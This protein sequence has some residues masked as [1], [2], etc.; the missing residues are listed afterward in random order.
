MVMSKKEQM[1]MLRA[2]SKASENLLD[3]EAVKLVEK[4]RLQQIEHETR[5]Q[6]AYKMYLEPAFL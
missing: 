4:V 5:S 3:R 6:G 1:K 2:K